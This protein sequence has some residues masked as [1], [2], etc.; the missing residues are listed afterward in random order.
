M[1]HYRARDR[2]WRPSLAHIRIAANQALTPHLADC[3]H[4]ML[5]LRVTFQNLRRFLNQ[6]RACGMGFG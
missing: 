4:V 3:K 1:G 6:V 5:W 2:R